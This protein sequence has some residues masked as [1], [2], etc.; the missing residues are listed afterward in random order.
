MPSFLDVRSYITIKDSKPYHVHEADETGDPRYYGYCNI[1]GSWV[2]M[3]QT[4]STGAHRYIFGKSAFSTSW[5]GKSGLS[6]DYIFNL[7]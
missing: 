5:T 1:D 3:E 4:M 2:I 6:Y 7:A